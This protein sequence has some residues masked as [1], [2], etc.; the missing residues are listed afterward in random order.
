MAATVIFAAMYPTLRR[1]YVI[2]RV[3]SAKTPME[4]RAAFRLARRYSPYFRAESVQHPNV[5]PT[6]GEE[7]FLTFGKAAFFSP[8]KDHRSSARRVLLANTNL[9]YLLSNV[10]HPVKY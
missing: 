5:E 8:V 6:E 1:R 9:D 4:E 3:E 7:M 10:L 2:A